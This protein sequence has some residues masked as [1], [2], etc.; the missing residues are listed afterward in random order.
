MFGG[1]LNS[2][3]L[4][5]LVELAKTYSYHKVMEYR[6]LVYDIFICIYKKYIGDR[7]CYAKD[8]VN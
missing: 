8:L 5:D 6:S 3:L 1:P 7:S 2:F 4:L